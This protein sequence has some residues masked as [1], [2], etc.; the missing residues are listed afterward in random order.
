MTQARK[1][2][3]LGGGHAHALALP[4]LA[5][6]LPPNTEISLLSLSRFTPYSGMLPGVIAGHYSADDCHIDLSL[7]CKKSRAK[8][9][10]CEAIGIDT[11]QQQVLTSDG[12]A[13]D[14]D[15]LSIDTGATPDLSST[16]GAR[17]HSI[18]VKP[19]HSF[20]SRFDQFHSKLNK[21]ARIAVVGGGAGGVEISL[22]IKHRLRQHCQQLTLINA[23]PQILPDYHPI[24]RKKVQRALDN[25]GIAVC[26]DRRVVKVESTALHFVGHNAITAD[27]IFWCT[28]VSAPA[29]LDNTELARNREGFLA[30]N[31]FLQVQNHDNIFAAGDVATQLNHPRPKAGVFAVRQAPV[32][33]NNLTRYIEGKPLQRH[34][35]QQ[36]FLS[37]ITLGARKAVADR[38]FY[39]GSGTWVWHLKNAIDQRFMRALRT[40][41]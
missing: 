27:A 2:I 6:Q 4:I 21:P 28:G 15:L 17:E 14:F 16:P 7:L 23:N 41:R 9:V 33:A 34:Q 36:R 13:I 22:A 35:P 37:L 26:N 10:E 5:R 19:V 8:F 30:L 40:L 25:A 3:L 24:S 29:W 18:A 11:D 20:I 1:L 12:K 31:D 38:G 39:F 32:L